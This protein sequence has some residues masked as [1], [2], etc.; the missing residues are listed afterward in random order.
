MT[1]YSVARSDPDY[2]MTNQNS[3]DSTFIRLGCK[4]MANIF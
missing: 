2:S 3:D 1:D 4:V